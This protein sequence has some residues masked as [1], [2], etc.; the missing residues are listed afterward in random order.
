MISKITIITII[1]F[2]SQY[3]QKDKVISRPNELFNPSIDIL[4]F[5]DKYIDE[6]NKSYDKLMEILMEEKFNVNKL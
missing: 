2:I 6:I 3:I 5:Y 1:H 4:D